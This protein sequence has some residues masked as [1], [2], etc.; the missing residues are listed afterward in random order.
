MSAKRQ[1]TQYSNT[2]D[3]IYFKSNKANG[4][5]FLSSFWSQVDETAKQ[6]VYNLFQLD[7]QDIEVA[8]QGFIV[9]DVEYS[10]RE[11]FYQSQKWL[12][13]PLIVQDIIEQTTAVDAKKRN[14]YWK[15]LLNQS[16]KYKTRVEFQVVDTNYYSEPYQLTN[17][18]LIEIMYQGAYQQFNQNFV[19]MY[20]L[21]STEGKHLSE[22]PSRSGG[23]LWAGGPKGQDRLGKILEQV[24]D[25]LLYA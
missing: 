20:L 5:A 14:T 4:Y 15:H 6:A 22:V 12:R 24:R 18:D 9:D 19:L 8:E 3:T 23:G 16:T 7:D 21:L 11:H 2:Q 17:D 10:T 1:K 13:Y 25:E